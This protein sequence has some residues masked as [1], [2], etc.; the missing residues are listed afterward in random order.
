VQKWEAVLGLGPELG[1]V[2]RWKGI[3]S[4]GGWQPQVAGGGGIY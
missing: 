2:R 1:L 4:G 3:A